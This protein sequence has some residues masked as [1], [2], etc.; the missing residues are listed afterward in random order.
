MM[1]YQLKRESNS[2]LLLIGIEIDGIY[3]L[4]MIGASHT[5]IDSNALHLLGYDFSERIDNVN[6]ETAN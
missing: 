3:E 4:N 6:I 5:T 1:K 2:N